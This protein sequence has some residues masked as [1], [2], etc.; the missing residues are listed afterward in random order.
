[1]VKNNDELVKV[2]PLEIKVENNNFEKACRDF[3]ALFQK[4]RIIGLLK[5]KQFYEKPS[6]K[7]RRKKREAIER[8]LMFEMREKLIK[9]GE[10]EKRV[11][12]RKLKKQNSKMQ[13]KGDSE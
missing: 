10:W 3:K 4:E 6:D 13:P 9:S 1:M 8:K 11:K 12:K 2:T 5:E 7:K